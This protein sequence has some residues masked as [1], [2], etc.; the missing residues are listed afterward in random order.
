M[1]HHNFFLTRPDAGQGWS[2]AACWHHQ[3]G[4]RLWGQ[5][6]KSYFIHQKKKFFNS[7][8]M[9]NS[10]KMVL[11]ICIASSYAHIFCPLAIPESCTAIPPLQE[12]TWS[13][14]TYIRVPILDTECYSRLTCAVQYLSSVLRDLRK[15]ILYPHPQHP[16]SP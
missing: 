9:I 5:V 13:L 7:L 11:E 6:D 2:V 16:P 1:C 3:L 4:Y 14:H 15:C 12:P 10:I 8:H